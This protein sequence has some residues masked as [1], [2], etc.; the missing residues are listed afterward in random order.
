MQNQITDL[1]R[2]ISELNT[3]LASSSEEHAKAIALKTEE[4][5]SSASCTHEVSSSAETAL[6]T[7][8]AACAAETAQLEKLYTNLKGQME[9]TQACGQKIRFCSDK[10]MNGVGLPYW[11]E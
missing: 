8:N 5:A 3:Q 11:M 4:I 9:M 1:N 6:G 10:Y 2:Q 7:D